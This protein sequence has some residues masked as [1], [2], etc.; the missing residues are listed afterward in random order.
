M[1][2]DTVDDRESVD[3]FSLDQESDASHSAG[4]DTAA[5]KVLAVDASAVT[6][7]GQRRHP[8]DDGERSSARARGPLRRP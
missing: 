3:K 8:D 5:V 7:V 6:V 4:R 2:I 1:A